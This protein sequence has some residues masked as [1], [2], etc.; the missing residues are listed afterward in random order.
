M[1]RVSTVE[2]STHRG[3]AAPVP[4]VSTSEWSTRRHCRGPSSACRL[5]RKST[6]APTPRFPRVSTPQ[7]S[8]R[9]QWPTTFCACRRVPRV[10]TFEQSTRPPRHRN[11]ARV[12]SS[13][14]DMPAMPAA[15][16][17]CRPL[18]GRL[19]RVRRPFP[20][21]STVEWS[22]RRR[23]VASRSARVD[24][25]GGRHAH[26]TRRLSRESTPQQSTRERPT[27]RSGR[28][29]EAPGQEA[30][31]EEDGACRPANGRHAHQPP[32][33]PRVSTTQQST[34]ANRT[35]KIPTRVDRPGGSTIIYLLVTC[36]YPA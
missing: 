5:P 21:V 29:K 30:A 19:T 20:R 23:G 22:T 33:H 24:S 26:S 34:R 2:R 28:A 13:E 11:L 12:D 8:T 9:R 17:A 31:G 35:P 16:S 36:T 10:S 25:P 32:P 6:R 14:V 3:P 1:T 4:R 15:F 18:S 27:Q 7:R